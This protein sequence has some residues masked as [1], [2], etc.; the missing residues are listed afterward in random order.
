M[1]LLA[2]L[3]VISLCGCSIS[4]GFSLGPERWR[5]MEIEYSGEGGETFC[6]EGVGYNDIGVFPVGWGTH[7]CSRSNGDLGD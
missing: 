3:A 6:W 1:K 7:E 4:A 2:L 5:V